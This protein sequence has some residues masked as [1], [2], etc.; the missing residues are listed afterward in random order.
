MNLWRL[1]IREIRH[2]AL[3]FALGILAVAVAIACQVAALALLKI[4]RAATREI[5]AQK[6]TEVAEAGAKLEDSMRKIMKGLGFNVIVIPEDQDLAEMHIS[7]SI[8][9]TM[10]ESY[11]DRLAN[12]KIVTVNHLL[13]TVVQRVD[14][15]EKETSVLLYGTRGEVPIAHRDPKKPLLDAVP[16]DSMII[17]FALGKKYGLKAGDTTKLRGIDFKVLKVHAE[18]G[19]IDDSTVWINLKQAQEMLDMENLIHAIQALECHCAGDRIAMIREEISQILPGVQ[20]IERG[21][22]ALARAEARTK[23]AD[24]AKA[25]LEREKKARAE[26][27]AQRGR[28]AT[29]LVPAV[30][31]ACMVFI[32]LLAFTNAR[33]RATEVAMLRAIGLRA[34]QILVVFL[35][36][37][38]LFGLIGGLAGYA[39]GIL[40]AANS[41]DAQF[42]SEVL[43]TERGK[44]LLLAFGLA[45]T[46]AV[47]G[48]WIPATMASS[49]DPA[50]VLQKE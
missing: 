21:S 33:Q 10:P 40:V 8:S 2:R 19:S 13:P 17:G 1:I 36:K 24:Q 28:L 27:R 7:G 50:V 25:S 3:N 4:D 26:L 32:G 38:L 6:E 48:A 22:Q 43:Q 49:Q 46:L 5:L 37:S 16:R 45:P 44:W 41:A 11:V 34:G 42:L 20:A 39:A 35:G 23:A 29:T 31:I 15:P 12:S 47:V 14:W 9:K 18:R 30:M